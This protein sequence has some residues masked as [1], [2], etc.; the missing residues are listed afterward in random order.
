MDINS[1]G[2]SNFIEL[3]YDFYQTMKSNKVI[4]IYE[5]FVTHEI[6]KAFSSLTG[7]NIEREEEDA[8]TQKKVFY[9]LVECLENISKHS[10]ATDIEFGRGVF[11]VT[12]S[13]DKYM[14]TTGNTIDNNKVEYLK[15]MLNNINSLDQEGI[16]QL[17]KTQLKEGS[18]SEKGGAGLGFIS[19]VKKTG[20]KLDFSFLPLDSD[21]S[22]FIL[23]ST[24]S[25]KSKE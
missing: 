6:V 20:E 4:L 3:V 10:D 23:N 11:I 12:Q 18:L 24:V 13:E 14:I 16:K 21:K 1:K 15:N 25:R 19:I 9:V 7:A 8:N 2:S 22:F 17:Y 5:G